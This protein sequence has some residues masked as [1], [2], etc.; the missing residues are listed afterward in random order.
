MLENGIYVFANYSAMEEVIGGSSYY[1]SFPAQL[2]V[3]SETYVGN[4]SCVVSP[5]K[6]HVNRMEDRVLKW[7]TFYHHTNL[8]SV[9]SPQFEW[10]Y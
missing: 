9:F 5:T 10:I 2:V 3:V 7:L 4:K 6:T 8:T 1:F